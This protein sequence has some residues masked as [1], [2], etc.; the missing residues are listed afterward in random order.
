MCMKKSVYINSVTPN[1]FRGLKRFM[2]KSRNKSGM[3]ILAIILLLI[4][5]FTV[6]AFTFT[7]TLSLGSDNQDV[8]LLQKFLNSDSRT[9]VAQ[10]GLGS[11]G[12]ETTYFGQKTKDAVIRF[13]N[14]YAE[15]IL[16]P[17]GLTVGT[18]VVGKSSRTFLNKTSSTRQNSKSLDTPSLL[19]QD[20][21]KQELETVLT[22]P[23]TMSDPLF[24]ISKS[25]IKSKD[26][27]YVGSNYKLNTLD[28]YVGSNK[29]DTSCSY[30]E[31]SCQFKVPLKPGTYTLKTSDL[32]L[33]SYTLIILDENEL[34]PK[35]SVK[36]LSLREENIIKG[37]N[38]TKDIKIFTVY[39]VFESETSNN[40]FILKFPEDY[41]RN[42][43]ST[44]DGLFFIENNNGLQSKLKIIK[45]EI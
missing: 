22:S 20:T 21:L 40:T 34:T 37:V 15:E 10:T 28:F 13:Q 5:L 44:F 41:V 27:V 39:G 16:N 42:A 32:K 23:E 1:L 36:K 26:T 33:G 38:F 12:N 14:L 45:Y 3:T 18:G 4:P 6:K 25:K 17:Y 35:V 2:T 29:M 31:Y 7:Q 43:T 11:I 9:Q 8:F 30:S 19:I 24:F